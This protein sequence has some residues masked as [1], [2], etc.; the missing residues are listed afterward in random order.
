MSND[1]AIFLSRQLLWQALLIAM[2][3]VIAAMVC[4][5]IVSILQVITQIQDSSLSSVPKLLTTVLTLMLFGE[6]M[7]HALVDFANNSWA[8]IP[9]ILG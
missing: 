6:W 9:E 8:R 1:F 5:F 7:L 4:G 3:V 2:P